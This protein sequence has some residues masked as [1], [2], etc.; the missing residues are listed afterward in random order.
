MRDSNHAAAGFFWTLQEF[1][2]VGRSPW[3]A[4]RQHTKTGIERQYTGFKHE[5][6]TLAKALGIVPRLLPETTEARFWSSTMQEITPKRLVAH[7][8]HLVERPPDIGTNVVAQH[9]NRRGS[10]MDT[11]AR[12]LA[13]KARGRGR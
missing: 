11:A 12:E 13:A 8:K 10:V 1:A 4:L 7:G 5:M 9:S 6:E 3:Y 2:R